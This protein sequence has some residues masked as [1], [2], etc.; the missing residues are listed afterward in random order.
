MEASLPVN[1]VGDQWSVEE[2][3]EPLPGYQEH[4]VEEHVQDVLGEHQGVQGGTLIYGILVISFQLIKCD[5]L[6]QNC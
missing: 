1:V 3:R 2:D 4:E 5:D 6:A